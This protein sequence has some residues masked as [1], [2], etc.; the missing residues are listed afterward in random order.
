MF[1]NSVR[2]A[3][4]LFVLASGFAWSEVQADWPRWRGPDDNGSTGVGSYPAQFDENNTRWQVALPGKGCSTPIVFDQTIYLTAPVNGKDAILS[5]G[6]SGEPRWSTTFGP[7]DAGKH[8][9]GSGSNASPVTDGNAVFAYFKSGTLA[10]V[11]LDGSVRWQT[12]LVDRFG[13]DTLFWD[14]G[15]SPVLTDKYVIMTRMH[16]G[17]SWLAAFDKTSGQMAWKVARDY[18]TPTECDHG[19]TTPLVIEHNGKQALLVWGA[20][21]LTIHDAAD[22][23]VVWSCGNFNPDG[24]KMWPA[25]ATPVIVGEMAV[26]CFGRNDRGQP[27]LH[28]IRLA[29]SGDVTA[30][31]HVWQRDDVGSFVPTPAVHQGRVYLLRD[32]GE[33]E[34]IDPAT[35]KT[36]WS[37]AFPK[38]R[39][40]FYASPLIAGGKLYATRED[41]VV[42]VA[43]VKDDRF[44]LL[45]ENDMQE[46]IIGS[47]VPAANRIFIRGEK[48][49]FCLASPEVAN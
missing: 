20:E 3:T 18:S 25:I 46:S 30:S 7:E 2:T 43:S 12:N 31:N 5:F 11:E 37:D 48:H 19:Y 40:A 14:H 49:L 47:P 32:R 6:W 36:I 38:H 45:A 24:N 29:G 42:F 16:R 15:T 41:G 23:K 13:K 21:H 34:C 4:F 27:R 39:A 28:G 8:R 1:V 26:I 44:E 35:G 33:V 10:A 9:N 17:E 22:G